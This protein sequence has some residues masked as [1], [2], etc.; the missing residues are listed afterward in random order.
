MFFICEVSVNLM[1]V[2]SITSK[3]VGETERRIKMKTMK[4]LVVFIVVL[5]CLTGCGENAKNS[6]SLQ[7]NDE[8]QTTTSEA[9]TTTGSS[10]Q[11]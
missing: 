6:G 3:I 7:Q 9:V 8:N 11:D 1:Y 5:L 10:V 4:V 2:V